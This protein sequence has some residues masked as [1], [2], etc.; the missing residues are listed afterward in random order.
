M[1][2]QI[3]S[4]FRK[5]ILFGKK[6][7]MKRFLVVIALVLPV[8][9]IAA[10]VDGTEFMFIKHLPGFAPSGYVD[11]SGPQAVSRSPENGATGVSTGALVHLVFDENVNKGSGDIVISESGVEFE[12]VAVL[13]GAVLVSGK[14][15]T[16]D[17]V[18]SLAR[19]KTYAVSVPTGA[20]EDARGNASVAVS[21]WSFETIENNAPSITS[22][23]LS[24]VME[25]TPYSYF[26]TA[27]DV[28][29]DTLSFSFSGPQ[30]AW[31]NL[32]DYGNGTATLWGTPQE[33]DVGGTSV[34]LVVSDGTKT[35]E[36][37]FTIAVAANGTPV[38]TSSIITQARE[39]ELYSYFAMV[40]DSLEDSLSI[41]PETLPGWLIFTAD[42]ENRMASLEGTP[43]ESDV[44][45][46][47]VA[48]TVSDGL[49]TAQQNFTISIFANDGPVWASPAAG[50]L[51]GTFIQGQGI[52]PVT[53]VANDTDVPV[54]YTVAAGS[55]P[56]GLA[57]NGNVLEGTPTGAGDFSFTIM[58]S[59]NLGANNARS[60]D[61]VV[62]DIT[63]NAF[64]FNNVTGAALSS[65]Q[66]SNAVAIA[67]ITGNVTI[68]VAGGSYNIDGG[69][70]I[71]SPGT[72]HAG[73][74]VTVRQTS[75]A[76]LNTATTT[77]LTIGT[78]SSSWTVTTLDDPCIGN[79]SVGAVCAD[80]TV[81]AGI[82][83]DGNLPMYVTRC[84]AGQSWDGSACAGT[85]SVMSWGTFGTATNITNFNTGEANT[86]ALAA[87][88]DTLAAKY[89][90]NLDMHGKDDWYLPARAEL[91]IMYNNGALIGGFDLSN[92]YP[93][94]Y[95]SSSE[96]YEA[97]YLGKY[98]A[99]GQRENVSCQ[100]DFAKIQ[101][102]SVRCARR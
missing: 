95:W 24:S 48:L 66:T 68:S 3:R 16:I 99:W 63:P 100:G 47:T 1:I 49:K 64:S 96:C 90:Q 7:P 46:H 10:S 52:V 88:S 36:Q 71:T 50:T 26:L 51:S 34:A 20:F 43:M 54:T 60:F 4:F 14:E 55:L 98:N 102:I 45:N 15:A 31:L 8:A 93:N 19:G 67:G 13:S 85:R 30:P 35:A 72:I 94:I 73:Q 37:A 57:L 92:V 41:T 33:D 91:I 77:T 9:A 38:F 82:S 58:V 40:D 2:A 42:N 81:Y 53:F 62:Q 17:P 86:A 22:L 101:K 79:P 25:G 32:D 27:E 65:V 76:A 44:G 89:C 23:P 6:I 84:D 69:S 28:E 56:A 61:M 5:F 74:V 80:G 83:P 97:Q 70:Y 18:S 39:G 78:V 87:L 75:S 11:V 29:G 59:D 21:G 12:R